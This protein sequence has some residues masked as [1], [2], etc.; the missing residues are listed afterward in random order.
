M[1]YAAKEALFKA[2]G[3]GKAGGMAWS[4]VEIAW[5]AGAVRP[6]MTLAGATAAAAMAMG[7]SAVHLATALT[8]SLAVGAVILEGQR[9]QG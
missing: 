3:T 5:P 6:S 4:D 7:V 9:D 8:K 2:I 1:A